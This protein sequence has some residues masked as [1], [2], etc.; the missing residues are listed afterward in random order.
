MCAPLVPGVPRISGM[1]GIL[2]ARPPFSTGTTTSGGDYRP[3]ALC[4]V[5]QVAAG[6]SARRLGHLIRIPP[7]RL[8]HKILHSRKGEVSSS[9]SLLQACRHDTPNGT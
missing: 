2:R 1:G 9:A 3:C 7:E 4:Y 5:L 6:C 8:S